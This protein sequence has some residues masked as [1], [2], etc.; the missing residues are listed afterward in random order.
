MQI[1]SID[2][3]FRFNSTS[4]WPALPH[5]R[6]NRHCRAF[7][8]NPT[9]HTLSLNILLLDPVSSRRQPSDNP[10]RCLPCEWNSSQGYFGDLRAGIP[11]MLTF[12][13]SLDPIWWDLL[14]SGLLYSAIVQRCLLQRSQQPHPRLLTILQIAPFRGCLT[15]DGPP[16]SPHLSELLRSP[17]PVGAFWKNRLLPAKGLDPS[18]LR[19]PAWVP[20]T[21]PARV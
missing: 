12:P 5:G 9:L 3:Y 1:S 2:V 8:K 17:L 13:P 6:S 15:R 14:G 18:S 7:N 21:R 20:H 11:S 4:F 10:P 16:R 19:Y